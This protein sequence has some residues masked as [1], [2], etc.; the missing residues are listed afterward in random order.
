MYFAHTSSGPLQKEMH[1]QW[2]MCFAHTWSG[3]LP[4]GNTLAI[5][6]DVFA[7]LQKDLQIASYRAYNK[8]LEWQAF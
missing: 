8:T 1:L 2:I 3:P 7:S 6:H 5:D 4:K